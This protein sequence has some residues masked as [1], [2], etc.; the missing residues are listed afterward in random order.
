MPSL[1]PAPP[2]RLA[3]ALLLLAGGAAGCGSGDEASGPLGAFDV[4]FEEAGLAFEITHPSGLRLASAP[5]AIGFRSANATYE[6]DA[7]SFLITETPRG[8]WLDADAFGEVARG[9]GRVS[10]QLGALGTLELRA[11]GDN[12]ILRAEPKD[13]SHNRAR[14]RLGCDAPSAGG[15]LGFGAQTFDVDH[16]GQIVPVFVSEQGIGKTTTDVPHPVWNLVGTRHQSYLAVPLLL[17]PRAQA[18]FGLFSTTLYRSIWDLC[19]TDPEV[20][21]VE[22]WEGAVELVVS[23][24]TTPLEVIEA[25]TAKTGRTPLGPD[26]TFGVWMERVGGTAEVRAEAERLRQEHIPVSALWSEDFRGGARVGAS[27]YVLEEDWRWDEA[28]Y[29]DLPGLIAELGTL[30]IRFMAYANTFAVEGS[31]VFDALAEGGHLVRDRRGEPFMFTAPSFEPSGL[32][33]LFDPGARQFVR[34]ELEGLLALGVSGWMADFAEWYPADPRSVAPSDGSPPEAAHHRY[35]VAWAEVNREAIEASGRTDVVVFHR[36]GYLGAQTKAHVIWAGDQRTS[37]DVDDGLPTIIPIIAGLGVAGFPIV[38]HD[39]AGYVSATN[40][41][42]SKELFLRWTTLGAMNPVMRTHHGRSAFANWRWSSDAET[43]AC[44]RRWAEL[45]TRL[46]PTW[47]GL[48]RDAERTGAP[49]LRPLALHYPA[50]VALH[51]VRDQ[52]LAG[53]ALLV[54]PVVTASVSE[55]AVVVPP[56]RW[57]DLETGEAVEGGRTIT[58]PAGPCELPVLARAGAI[59]PMLPEGVESLVETP[60]ALDLGEVRGRRDV[61][62]WLGAP[63][64]ATDGDGGALALASPATVSGR[65]VSVEGAGAIERAEPNRQVFELPPN[66]TVVLIDEAGVRHELSSSGLSAVMQV[67]ADVRW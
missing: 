6:M 45:H 50:E 44:F 48:A 14:I 8:D 1:Q 23:A 28:L 43:T 41:P 10:L 34:R 30:G 64:R 52:Y 42:A 53:D 33:D 60:V 31:D 54:A 67:R 25:Q 12:L 66:T 57:F 29:P 2:H 32:A 56:G 26:W 35:P 15:F 61:R 21:A 20:L 18:S 24:G 47:K 17:A 59:L 46:F 13:P 38:T 63:G 11:E 36:S 27:D 65:I 19:A 7:G 3:V 16:R 37:F 5:G 22:V 62:V 4:R 39:I 9:D 55:R 40:P 58:R 51:G 49:V